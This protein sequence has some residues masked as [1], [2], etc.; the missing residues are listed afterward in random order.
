M[1]NPTLD[2]WFAHSLR[3]SANEE[4]PSFATLSLLT[5]VIPC[6]ARQDFLL[7][8]CVYWH[9]SGAS[10]VIVDGS[11]QP[12]DGISRQTL[13]GLSD[14]IYLHAAIS[15]SDRLKMASKHIRTPYA[16]LLGDDEFFLFSGLCSAILALER[17]ASLSACIAQSL[18]FHTMQDGTA[19]SYGHGY[20]H[21]R[22]TV[23]QDE[24]EQRLQT[25]MSDYTAATCYAVLRAPVWC[26]SWGQ[27]E[28]WSSPYVSEMQQGITTYIWG[29]LSTVDEV[30]WMRS[31]E[32]RSITSTDFNRGLSF[33]DWWSSAQFETEHERF[34]AI[35]TRELKSAITVD[36][37]RARA[38]VREAVETFIRHL[39]DLD[40]DARQ[41]LT[42][43]GAV[44]NTFRKS[45]AAIAKRLL[46]R[47]WL[48]YLKSAMFGAVPAPTPGNYGQLQDLQKLTPPVEFLIDDRLIA[49]LSAMENL[50]SGFYRAR[51]GHAV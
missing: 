28:N 48:E 30:Y 47:R 22:Y 21:W 3:K 4:N 17:D 35:L 36:D 44:L 12:L 37:A 2:S 32:N 11:P 10:V 50:I 41:A 29:K 25:A 39:D 7:R 26:K 46:P 27:L 31:S 13:D 5:V 45:T 16:T 1:A 24:I 20:P 40:R 18:A 43:P 19:C 14:V 34:F 38:V 33:R 9:G 23:R 8:Q 15:M 42:G 6:Y 49:E 51:K